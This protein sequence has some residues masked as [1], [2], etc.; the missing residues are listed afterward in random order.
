M[1]IKA[2]LKIN[3]FGLCVNAWFSWQPIADSWMGGVPTK[4]LIRGMI[5]KF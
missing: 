1:R 3:L 2:V 5:L 4:V